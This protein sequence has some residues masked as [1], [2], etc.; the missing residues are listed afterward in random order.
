[1]CSLSSHEVCKSL[2]IFTCLVILGVFFSKHGKKREETDLNFTFPATDHHCDLRGQL[3][4]K[5]GTGVRE[6]GVIIQLQRKHPGKVI[7][8]S[9]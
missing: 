9:G 7:W 1:M 3:V 8:I 4:C 6:R 2:L 5:A